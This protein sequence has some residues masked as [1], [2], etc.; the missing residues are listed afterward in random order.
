MKIINMSSTTFRTII[1]L[2]IL[3]IKLEIITKNKLELMTIK[4]QVFWE[5][6]KSPLIVQEWKIQKLDKG[7]L[8]EATEDKG[9]E[10]N[11]SK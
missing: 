6:R 7:D 11:D 8:G 10:T 5:D 3:V 4:S 1:G 9:I 2:S